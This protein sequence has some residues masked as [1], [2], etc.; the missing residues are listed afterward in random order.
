[1]VGQKSIRSFALTWLV[2]ASISFLT[3]RLFFSAV[4]PRVDSMVKAESVTHENY[5]PEESS[6]LNLYMA[7]AIPASPSPQATPAEPVLAT[8]TDTLSELARQGAFVVLVAVSDPSALAGANANRGAYLLL[9]FDIARRTVTVVTLAPDIPLVLPNRKVEQLDSLLS[10]KSI[11]GDNASLKQTLEQN[12]SIP[13]SYYLILNRTG[14]ERIVDRLGGVTIMAP[15]GSTLQTRP[16]PSPTSN[17]PWRP[18]I[19][20]LT[21]SSLWQHL[22]FRDGA[23]DSDQMTRNHVLLAGLLSMIRSPGVFNHVLSLLVELT[24]QQYQT[25][26]QP[27]QLLALTLFVQSMPTEAVSIKSIDSTWVKSE[28]GRALN[29]ER[30]RALFAELK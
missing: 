7:T 19:Q 21:G 22:T 11:T 24:A 12:L 30:V 2:F 18:G 27:N 9:R 3:G 6:R 4:N 26:M 5:V 1:M 14:L 17:I 25:N 20:T 10:A 23:S 8:A 29:S 16:I 13:I 15:G 28:T